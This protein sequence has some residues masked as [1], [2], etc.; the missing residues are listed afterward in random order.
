M[1]VLLLSCIHTAPPDRRRAILDGPLRPAG[2]M[3]NEFQGFMS[4]STPRS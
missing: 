2:S 4:D 3:L 1:P